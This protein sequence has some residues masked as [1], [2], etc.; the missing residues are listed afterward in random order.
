MT[1]E[2][3]ICSH[4][5]E[6]N[7]PSATRCLYC[8]LP[9]EEAFSVEGIKSEPDSSEQQDNSSEDISSIFYDL[10]QEKSEQ[11]GPHYVQADPLSNSVEQPPKDEEQK[12]N[13]AENAQIPEWLEKIRHRAK[14][15]ADASGEF[16]KKVS[17]RDESL[18]KEQPDNV[19]DEFDSWMEQIREQA[20]RDAALNQKPEQE[21]EST[22]DE[23]G[24]PKWLKKLRE[25]EKASQNETEEEET[26]QETANNLPG[27]IEETISDDEYE[28]LSR[29][30][31]ATIAKDSTQ[32]V[33]VTES[34]ITEEKPSLKVDIK[35]N[36]G[37]V[38]DDEKRA[39]TSSLNEH[40]QINAENITEDNQPLNI[41]EDLLPPDPF[42]LLQRE[43]RESMEV[44]KNL[45]ST[46]G[47]ASLFQKSAKK[48]K[49]K[50]FRLVL[51]LI[52]LIMT[53]FPF[54]NNDQP[55]TVQGNMHASSLAFL[56]SLDDLRQGSNVL[57]VIDYQ[58][59]TSAEMELLAKPVFQ[60][61]T[62]KEVL[63]FPITTFPEG[64]WLAERFS[65]IKTTDGA[66]TVNLG[67][68]NF[69]PGGRLGT[70][71]YVIE[72]INPA[73]HGIVKSFQLA[74]I[75]NLTDFDRIIVFVDSLQSARNW[76]EQVKPYIGEIPL[77]MVSSNQ[78]VAVLASYY[79]SGQ[80]AG[81]LYGY[82][83]AGV[84]SSKLGDNST[85]GDFWRSYQSGLLVMA[86]L[87][88]IGFIFRLESEPEPETERETKP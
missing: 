21:A 57:L 73:K 46:E 71:N 31:A 49:T 87:L 4:C 59:S 72:D 39:S 48:P 68:I 1:N 65:Q 18:D 9:L 50:P 29:I 7:L 69:L 66:Q 56:E 47:K 61:L 75:N 54:I 33:D 55:I 13:T 3:I 22:E 27:W 19:D 17:A 62:S 41:V 30:D 2:F 6:E 74:G 85:S 78:E 80:L 10:H 15:E 82:H 76:L 28:E 77:L 40:S 86:I 14:L 64:L 70:L 5:G 51:A 83:D 20:R 36:G 11:L 25:L 43:Q 63:I 24:V 79:D 37:E 58:P 53:I 26:P 38:T 45:I 52:L 60:H 8:G 12:A 23:D 84:Y 67:T 42:M 88:V 32:P 16:I 44:L 34:E 35:E 81:L